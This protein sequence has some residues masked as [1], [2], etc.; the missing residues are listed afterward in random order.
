M[1]EK[2][3]AA[4]VVIKDFTGSDRALPGNICGLPLLLLVLIIPTLLAYSQDVMQGNNQEYQKRVLESAEVDFL[5]SYYTQDGQNAAVSGG[6]GNENLTDATGTIEVSIPLTADD[7]LTISGEVSAYSSA[8]S[9]N[10]DPFDG[11]RPADPYVASSGASSS[12]VWGNFTGN[13]SHSSEDRNRIW[14]AKFSV[15][16]EFD[17]FSIGLGGG[18][19]WLFN[20]KNTELNLSGN[21][22]LDTWKTI[23]PYELRPFANGRSS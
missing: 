19:S 16:A 11:R 8:S 1:E 3:E 20:D 15:A 23:Y 22:Y 17:Y 21:I 6:I 14:S 10:I 4:V 5:S 13:Y 9:S 7:V 2:P 18:Y 12:D